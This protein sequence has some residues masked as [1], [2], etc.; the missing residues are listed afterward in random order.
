MTVGQKIQFYRKRQNMSQEQLGQ[1][2]FV[3]RQT[4]SLWEKDQTLPT[5]DNLL[6]L[7]EIFG[8][9]IDELLTDGTEEAISERGKPLESF[10]VTYREGD[11]RRV[12]MGFYRKTMTR[13]TVVTAALFLFFVIYILNQ[14]GVGEY[15]MGSGFLFSLT[16]TLMNYR[17]LKNMIR[18]GC[19]QT[20]NCT[21]H[22][23][24]YEDNLLQTVSRNGEV[25]STCKMLFSELQNMRQVGELIVFSYGNQLFALRTAELGEGSRFY[26][27]LRSHLAEKKSS[28]RDPRLTAVS[29]ILFVLSIAS[30]WIA[31]IT[32]LAI[33]SVEAFLQNMWILLCFLPIPL[34]SLAFGILTKRKGYAY[35]KNVVVGI[36]MAAFLLIYGLLGLLSGV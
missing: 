24:V 21:Y 10:D 18:L 34:G 20:M 19:R 22:Y 33:S 17:K 5:I 14:D 25:I 29:V 26:W 23:D 15:I 32:N 27:F 2:L 9:S 8:V 30:L 35:K 3:S 1:L 6:K 7:R 12:T 31:L 13:M 4:I 16:L 28:R 11:I 36:I